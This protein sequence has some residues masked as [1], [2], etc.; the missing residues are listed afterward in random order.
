MGPINRSRD[1]STLGSPQ[2]VEKRR[3]SRAIL[4]SSPSRYLTGFVTSLDVQHVI[5]EQRSKTPTQWDRGRGGASG[6]NCANFI[7]AQKKYV[8]MYQS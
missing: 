4:S 5:G 3:A 2:W 8:Q 1:T 7:G 6:T